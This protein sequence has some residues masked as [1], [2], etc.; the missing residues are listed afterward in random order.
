MSLHLPVLVANG[1]EEIKEIAGYQHGLD[2]S[3]C[4]LHRRLAMLFRSFIG[5]PATWE[6]SHHQEART[7]RSCEE[8]KGD[9]E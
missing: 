2:F 7:A 4:G 5:C 9:P 1:T 8:T 6:A 3:Y